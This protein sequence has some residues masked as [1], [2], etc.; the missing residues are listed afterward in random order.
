M[1]AALLVLPAACRKPPEPAPEQAAKVAPSAPTSS[2]LWTPRPLSSEVLA[3]ERAIQARK[4]TLEPEP[5]RE[6]RLAFGKGVL[7]QLTTDELR[8]HDAESG[9]LLLA[10]PVVGPRLLVALAD[11]TLLAV[12]SQNM[13]RVDAATKKVTPLSKP[14]LLPGA[15]LFA[16]AINPDRIWVFDVLSGGQGSQVK[17][18]LAAVALDPARIGISLPEYRVELELPAGGVLG[19]TREGVWLYAT[20]RGVER[21]GPGGAR[22][23]KLALP[24]LAELLWLLPM[25]RLDQCFVV[26]R[27]RVSRALVTPSFRQLAGSAE[28]AGTPLSAAVGDEGRLLAVVVV[29]G[30]GP[31]FELQLFDAELKEL[32][33]VPLPGDA[34]TGGPDWVKVVT[35]NQGVVVAPGAAR[36]AVGG[37]GRVL[38]LDGQ[39][40][41]VFSIPSQ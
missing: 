32:G 36:V 40:K 28:L 6:P 12:G 39:G 3:V 23:S 4:L 25:R 7:G 30:E 26:E 16:D 29:A 22:L 19:R 17:P 2:S 21:F 10:K 41:Q 37:P 11:G 13:L 9:K 15:E 5:R 14:V 35:Q 8:V 38:V 1:L 31:R 24:E 20:G 33:R 34:P 27:R 18:T